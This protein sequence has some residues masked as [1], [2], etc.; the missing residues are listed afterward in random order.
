MSMFVCMYIYI[1]MYLCI[2][3]YLNIPLC[4]YVY[5]DRLHRSLRFAPLGPVLVTKDE[6]PDPGA[7]RAASPLPL[8]AC[9]DAME[10][11]L[12]IYFNILY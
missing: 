5:T 6:I 8:R 1:Y 3:I 11:T 12:G 7:L 9:V 2:Y 4:I 10:N